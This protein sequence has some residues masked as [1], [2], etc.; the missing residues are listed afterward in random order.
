MKTIR[1]GF[2]WGVKQLK[3]NDIL[4][5]SIDVNILLRDT[6]NIT[7][8]SLILEM[9]KPF[10]A[11]FQTKYKQLIERRIKGESVAKIRKLKY[12]WN[13]EFMTTKD[14]LD[15]RPE[16]EILVE[17]CKN[18]IK[19]N[20][21]SSF[22]DLGVGTGC[23]L[24][25]LLKEID[26]LF[27]I[28]T[29]ISNNALKIARYNTIKHNVQNRCNLVQSKWLTSF[30]KSFDLIVCNPPYIP[31]TLKDNLPLE[32]INEPSLALFGGEEGLDAF[33]SFVKDIDR[34]LSSKGYLVVEIGKGQAES[35][36]NIFADY[37]LNCI[38][39]YNDFQAIVRCLVFLKS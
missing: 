27:G 35:V 36:I 22:I 18:I 21:I 33:R 17:V 32:V 6:L 19:F 37:G 5:P 39:S 10:I 28:G 23:I 7:N 15:P 1:D 3:Q 31:S 20:K 13:L 24:I 16:T 12:F 29:D 9:D 25:S 11:E 30:T 2:I 38:E 4:S 14:T 26:N 34:V 8:S